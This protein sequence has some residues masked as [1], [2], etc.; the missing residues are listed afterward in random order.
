MSEIHKIEKNGVTIYPATTTDAVVD[1]IRKKNI[2]DLLYSSEQYFSLM[3]SL[4][5]D[6]VNQSLSDLNYSSKQEEYFYGRTGNL[7]A[8]VN[9]KAY[10]IDLSNLSGKCLKI[11]FFAMG[12]AY[13]HVVGEDGSINRSYQSRG[14]S[15]VYILIQDS[16]KKLLLSNNGNYDCHIINKMN[17]FTSE[18]GESET[19]GLSQKFI[20]TILKQPLIDMDIIIGQLQEETNQTPEII[21]GKYINSLGNIADLGA[22]DLYVY[23]V[24]KGEKYKIKGSGVGSGR[25]Y[26]IYSSEQMSS[27]TLLEIG[28]KVSESYEVDIIIPDGGVLLAATKHFASNIYVSKKE[29][30]AISKIEG[31]LDSLEKSRT[32][33]MYVKYTGEQVYIGSKF[34]EN[35]DLLI[36]FEKCMFNELMTFFQIGTAKNESNIPS[37]NCDREIENILNRS[38]SDNIGPININGQFVGGNHSY[39]NNSIT[40]TAFCKKYQV[41]IDGEKVD[42]EYWGPCDIIEILVENEIYD[43]SSYDESSGIPSILNDVLCQETVLYRICKNS[44][45]V[46]LSHKY[47]K[48]THVSIYYGMQSMFNNEEQI[49]TPNGKYI[50]FTDKENIQSFT[51][52][53]YPSFTRFIEK[54]GNYCQSSYLNPSIGLGN[55]QYIEERDSVYL[56]SSTK[57]YHRV[58]GNKDVSAGDILSWNGIY[59]WFT[60]IHNND[61][62]LVYEANTQNGDILFL[63][64]KRA[65]NKVMINL[66]QKYL[67]KQPDKIIQKDD[68]IAFTDDFITPMGINLSANSSGSLILFFNKI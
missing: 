23:K 40:K 30:N 31:R 42:S 20:S 64:V 15:Y 19:V 4:L 45:E 12:N 32:E 67:G 59:S 66:P 24:L 3:I 7:I 1:G 22:Y 37:Q 51:K 49:M 41:Y 44:I 2:G 60:P 26:A 17:I 54:R 36:H 58:I 55:K 6:V 18:Y 62:L 56:Y 53:D 21:T 5:Q 47:E 10:E 61:N 63:D 38:S 65:I 27:S 43:P 68:T 34:D 57:S 9:Y 8:L 39:D 52:E 29:I 14:D 48:D 35:N 46:S 11:K 25:I 16:D 13:T 50:E 33:I 28:N